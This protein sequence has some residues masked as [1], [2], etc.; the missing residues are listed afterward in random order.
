MQ[1]R[2]TD[3]SEDEVDFSEISIGIFEKREDNILSKH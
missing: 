2:Y 1:P 3:D